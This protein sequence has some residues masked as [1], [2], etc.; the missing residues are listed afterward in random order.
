MTATVP[1]TRTAATPAAERSG[2]RTA[3]ADRFRPEVQGLRAVAVLL[4]V[5]YHLWPNRLTG[6]YVGVDVFF[7]ISGFLITS[8]IARELETTGT[9]GL[10]RFWARRI[11]RLLPAS[12]LV[13]AVSAVAVVVWVEPTVWA[14]TAKQLAASAFYVQNWVLAADAVDYMAADNVPTVA[15]HYWSLSVEEQ[16][17]LLWPVLLLGLAA[18][19]RR[20]SR[21]PGGARLSRRGYLLAGLGV[22]AAVSLVWSVLATARDQSSAYFITPTRA[23][24]FAAGALLAL[25]GLGGLRG[26]RWRGPVAWAGLVAIVASGVLYDGATLFPGWV[27]AVPVLGT[28]AV[29]AAGTTRS[30]FTPAPWL[31]VRPMR[32]VGDISYSVYLWHWPLIVVWPA[33]TDV[34]LRTV[35]KVGVLV[36][37]VLLAWASKVWVE[38]PARTGR[39]LGPAPWRAFAFAGAGMAV[40]VAGAAG[41]LA[42]V[43][44]RADAA[45]AVVA[46]AAESGCFGPAALEPDRGCDPPEGTGDLVPPPEVVAMQNAEPAY[47]GCQQTLAPSDLRTCVLGSDSGDPEKVVA[48]V[49][50]SHAT[51]WFPAF[52]DLGEELDWEV[53][54]YT[55][56]SCPVSTATRVLPS[57]QTD[58]GELSCRDWNERVMEEL[59]SSEEISAVFTASYSTAYEFEAAQDH[60]LDA[61]RTDGFAEAWQE[62]RD[63]GLEVVAIS[64]VPRTQ[65][66]NVPNCLALNPGDRM[67]C[68]VPREEALPGSAVADAAATLADDPGVHLVDLS[69]QLCDEEV[70]YP[71]VGDLIAYRDYSHLSAEYAR[72]LV[73]W[74]QAELQRSGFA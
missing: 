66:E 7:V 32:F 65:G 2:A 23:W 46:E 22:L 61:P 63:A 27:A 35:D 51:Q 42:E 29:I 18:W 5:L 53:R 57:E 33:V 36:L 70:C 39:L 28:V 47:P 4:V 73:P 19:H 49:G 30:L 64:D 54:T 41:V 1:A 62:L 6:G 12:L 20:A 34:R 11:R 59:T 60:P 71:V 3:A 52:D 50:D 26:E 37:T 21:R 14:Q 74:I 9:I 67:A 48:L 55:K 43:D 72:A 45:A 44:R 8:H 31:S 15:Q 38:D 56:T 10:R 16:F 58:E 69:E 68:A 13:L 24:E 40:V 17:Y 25:V